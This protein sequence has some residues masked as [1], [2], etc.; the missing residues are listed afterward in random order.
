MGAYL[1]FAE[2]VPLGVTRRDG[3]KAVPA[4]VTLTSTADVTAFG[5]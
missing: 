3:P 5:T 4:C 2:E 1:V